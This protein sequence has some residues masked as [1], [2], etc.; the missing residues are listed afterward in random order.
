MDAMYEPYNAFYPRYRSSA[1][2][3][4]FRETI[5]RELRFANL[6][7]LDPQTRLH[8][9]IDRLFFALALPVISLM[10]LDVRRISRFRCAGASNPSFMNQIQFFTLATWLFL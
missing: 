2:G 5:R 1:P 4:L 10:L 9:S 8:S 6:C 7:S 3:L